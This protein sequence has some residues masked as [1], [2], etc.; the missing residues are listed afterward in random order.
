[1]I[2]GLYNEVDDWTRE[3]ERRLLDS[4][5]RLLLDLMA[6]WV[7][8]VLDS[9]SAARQAPLWSIIADGA[10]VGWKRFGKLARSEER[11]QLRLDIFRQ[12]IVQRRRA[13]LEELNRG[14]A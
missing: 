9:A 10:S 11:L 8:L 13:Q 3:L 14:R 6:E 1:M 7:Q 4:T 5:V 2:E 12:L